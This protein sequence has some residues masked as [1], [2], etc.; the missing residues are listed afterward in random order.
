MLVDLA[1]LA[2]DVSVE[3]LF[4]GLGIGQ[5]IN[6][7]LDADAATEVLADE[8]HELLVADEA[9]A[10][11]VDDLEDYPKQSLVVLDLEPAGGKFDDQQ[12]VL[13][14]EEELGPASELLG[15]VESEQDQLGEVELEEDANHVGVEEVA[16][17]EDVVPEESDDGEFDFVVSE[18]E[19]FDKESGKFHLTERLEAVELEYQQQLVDGDAGEPLLGT[20]LSVGVD[21]LH[22]W[23]AVLLL[24]DEGQRAE[25]EPQELEVLLVGDPAVVVQVD[26]AEQQRELRLGDGELDEGEGVGEG[27]DELG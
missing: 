16:A 23:L 19:D 21:G 7:V 3:L 18:P 20:Q 1:Q 25:V 12:E 8:R 14:T 13:E 22:G 11:R 27:L 5:G 4:R 9:V 10:V 2:P 17:A 26:L 24:V 6:E 15:A